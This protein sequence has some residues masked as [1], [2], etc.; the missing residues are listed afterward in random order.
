MLHHRTEDPG[1]RAWHIATREEDE[2]EWQLAVARQQPLRDWPGFI[3]PVY[4]QSLAELA[5]SL[6][7]EITQCDT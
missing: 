2:H 3:E 7:G 4:Q 5:G 6:D 1:R